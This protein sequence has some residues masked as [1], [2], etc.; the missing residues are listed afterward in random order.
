M[1]PNQTLPSGAD[2]GLFNGRWMIPINWPSNYT[3]FI[4]SY[5]SFVPKHGDLGRVK[6]GWLHKV[7]ETRMFLYFLGT[8]VFLFVFPCI[9][10]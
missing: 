8:H 6:A 2:P 5:L 4:L 1:V 10:F 7:F 3:E 9:I